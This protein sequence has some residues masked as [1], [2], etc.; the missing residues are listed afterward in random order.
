MSG[1]AR[2]PVRTAGILV[3]VDGSAASGRAVR[4]AVARARV[5]GAMLHVLQVRPPL[6]AGELG[7]LVTREMAVEHRRR[8]SERVLRRAC[9]PLVRGKVPHLAHSASGPVAQT[10]ARCAKALG[11]GEIVMATRG[12]GNVKNLLLG[13]IATRVVHYARV[14]VTL[15]K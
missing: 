10:I 6:M 13:S 11:C 12:M 1:A 3:P 5:S 15:I 2:R 8:E 9:A 7:A 14:P 4:H